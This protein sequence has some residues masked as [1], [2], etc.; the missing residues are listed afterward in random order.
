MIPGIL[1][2]SELR[3][4]KDCVEGTGYFYKRHRP[5]LLGVTLFALM[6]YGWL[7]GG[8]EGG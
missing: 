7:H 6:G 5:G 3:E 1:K 2:D 4:R 8:R